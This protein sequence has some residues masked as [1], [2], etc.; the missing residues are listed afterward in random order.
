LTI[1]TPTV[2][3]HAATKGYVDTE[4]AGVD[5]SGKANLS[6][7]T[8]TGAVVVP[9]TGANDYHVATKKY[10]DDNLNTVDLTSF[11]S[12]I[13][14]TQNEAFDIG[15]AE[16]KIRHIFISD[17]SLWIG[18]DHKID[19]A[20][21]KMKFKKRKKSVVPAA[22]TSANGTEALALAHSSAANLSAMTLR[23][24]EAYGLTLDVASKGIGNALVNDIFASGT[25]ADWDVDDDLN[26]A[27]EAVTAA[28]S[29]NTANTLVKRDADGN[30]TANRIT[31]TLLVTGGVTNATNAAAIDVTVLEGRVTTLEGSKAIAVTTAGTAPASGEGAIGDIKFD[32]AND[33]AYI[34][35]N[36]TTWKSWNLTA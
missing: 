14:P 24:W 2:A 5:T 35:T 21:G 3:L 26:A 7:A 25:S 28:A 27:S 18:D 36:A 4:I 17:N 15:S 34:K 13:L 23:Q 20:D 30:F 33:K 6:G 12:H 10:V 11:S 22:I 9:A 29:A 32:H 31:T 1:P 19:I 8:F 16:K